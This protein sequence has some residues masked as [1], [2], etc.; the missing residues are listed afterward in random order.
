MASNRFNYF[1]ALANMAEYSRQAADYL[2]GVIT[3]FD[4]EA[5]QTN[6]E[7]IHKIEHEA[8]MQR[9]EIMRHLAKEF[10]P[11]LEREDIISLS[12]T[13]DDI[14]DCIDDLIQHLYIYNVDVM[15]PECEEYSR[16]IVRCCE[17]IVS[18]AKE[19]SNFLKSS[20]ILQDIVV[21]H[22]LESEGDALYSDIMRRV[23]TSA[24]PD[25]K[26]FIWARIIGSFEDCCDY[27]EQAAELFESSIMKNS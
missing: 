21:T 4:P 10:L 9:H 22:N 16:L 12:S 18:I 13:I 5:L 3:D 14:T 26:V 17:S 11:P 27:C 7:E 6:I 23:F 25:R 15:L 24:M 20:T 19:F 1:D 8:D 2:H